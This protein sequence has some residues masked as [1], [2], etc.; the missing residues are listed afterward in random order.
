MRVAPR[1]GRSPRTRTRFDFDSRVH[2]TDRVDNVVERFLA[3][4]LR[5]VLPGQRDRPSGED[6]AMGFHMRSVPLC[7]LDA[8]AE[9]RHELAPLLDI[10]PQVDAKLL[11]SAADDFGPFGHKPVSNVA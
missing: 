11:R 8:Q 10:V 7:L 4:C 2:Y 9:R 5:Q 3:Q 6:F 1:A